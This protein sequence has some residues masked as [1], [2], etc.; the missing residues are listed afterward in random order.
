[1]RAFWQVGEGAALAEGDLVAPLRANM[2]TWRT[3]AVWKARDLLR[4]PPDALPVRGPP[5]SLYTVTV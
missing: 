3:L 2:G 1:M 4:L 5:G